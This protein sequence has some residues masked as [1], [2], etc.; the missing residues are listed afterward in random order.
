MYGFLG[1]DVTFMISPV[2][3]FEPADPGDPR[4]GE[5]SPVQELRKVLPSAT[6]GGQTRNMQQ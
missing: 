6:H 4:P 2:D 3:R 1:R 5:A